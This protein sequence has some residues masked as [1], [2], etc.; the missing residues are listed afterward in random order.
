M[1]L[2]DKSE[3]TAT[4]KQLHALPTWNPLAQVVI[5]FL[6]GKWKLMLPPNLITSLINKSLFSNGATRVGGTNSR[7][8]C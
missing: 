1:L 2:N 3:L 8:Y 4:I 6:R 7:S 5:F